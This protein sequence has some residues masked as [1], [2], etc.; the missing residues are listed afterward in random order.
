MYLAMLQETTGHYTALTLS[1]PIST[2]GFPSARK[3][4]LLKKY[5]LEEGG[6]G[7]VGMGWG[8]PHYLTYIPRAFPLSNQHQTVYISRDT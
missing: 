6:V 2:A 7:Q 4:L 8:E 1:S 5:L 3:I